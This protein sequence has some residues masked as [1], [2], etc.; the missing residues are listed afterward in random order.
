MLAALVAALCQGMD[1]PYPSVAIVAAFML[2]TLVVIYGILRL[3]HLGQEAGEATRSMSLLILR[4]VGIACACVALFFLFIF[5]AVGFVLWPVGIFLI[6]VTAGSPGRMK[7][8]RAAVVLSYVRQA[9]ALN[10]PLPA[11]LTAVARNEKGLIRLRLNRVADE[12]SS[13][14][15][16]STSLRRGLPEMTLRQAALISAAEHSGRLTQTL[17][18]LDRESKLGSP[19]KQMD[20]GIIMGYPLLVLMVLGLVLMGIMLLVVPKF[21]KIFDD[22]GTTL[23]FSTLTIINISRWLGGTLYPNQRAPGVVWIFSLALVFLLA[24]RLLRQRAGSGPLGYLLG[25]MPVF[26]QIARDQGMG[27]VCHVLEEATIA[28]V[29]PPA[30]GAGGGGRSAHQRGDAPGA[31]GTGARRSRREPPFPKAPR[32]RT[33]RGSWWECWRRANRDRIFRMPWPWSGDSTTIVWPAM[34]R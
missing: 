26:G 29:A 11:M 12:L 30:G 6:A 4:W 17:D 7:S 33:C 28:G 13:G 20:R 21:E 14:Q 31:C 10:L 1:G 3:R 16:I 8:Q 25:L 24:R 2:M 27:D 34:S 18:R 22:F 32:P 15:D 5:S 19:G 23:P 9:V